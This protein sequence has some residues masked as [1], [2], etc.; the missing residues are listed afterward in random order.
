MVRRL[1][2]TPKPLGVLLALAA[3]Q[4]I[5][6]ATLLPPLQ[7]PDEVAH[8]AYT[9]KLVEEPGI[10]W[11][12]RSGGEP[13]KYSTEVDV[14]IRWGGL[15]TVAANPAARPSWTA[16]DVGLWRDHAR[17]LGHRDRADGGWVTAMRNP[18]LYYVYEAIP[19]LVA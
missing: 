2:R 11:R 13:I 8:F 19:Y 15:S 6:W 18:P 5:V 12:S 7:G 3:V 14:A 9:Q 4:A 10:P 16:V 17:D 1:R